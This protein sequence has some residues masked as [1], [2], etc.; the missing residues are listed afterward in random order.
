M[1]ENEVRVVNSVQEFLEELELFGRS[2]N[3]I[4]GTRLTLRDFARSC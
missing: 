1:P 3:Y 2:Y 4:N